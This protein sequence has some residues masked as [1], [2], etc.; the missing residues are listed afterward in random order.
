[1][2]LL[3]LLNP[4]QKEAVITTA[5]P[6]LIL[7]GAGSGKT[8]VLTSRIAYMIKEQGINPW[9]I[10]AVTF[11]NKAARE[12]KDRI[13]K[14]I[15][16]E[17]RSMWVGTFHS[18]C[19][20]ILRREAERIGY[21]RDFVIYDRGDQTALI[22]Q[23]LKDYNLDDQKISPR[24]FISQISNLKNQFITP[25]KFSHKASD[26]SD[27]NLSNVY[28][29]YEKKMFKNNAFDF[30]D[31]IIKTVNLLHNFPDVLNV[32][33]DQF[34][35]VL[36]D[37]YQDT[38]RSQYLLIT[39][40][41]SKYRNICVVG[42]DDQ[43]IYGWRGADI[44]NI[45]NFDRDFKE[46]K[47]IKLEQNYRST[48]NI[49]GAASAVIKNNV[50]RKK[51]EIWSDQEDGNLIRLINVQ[52]ERDEILTI[53]DNINEIKSDGKNNLSS[54]AILYRTNAQSRVLEEG[55]RREG[56]PYVIFG[57]TQFYARKE[58]KDVL[59]Y[60]KVIVNP[61][62]A[63]SL[64]RII[65]VPKRDIGDT[66]VAKLEMYAYE[67]SL[68]LYEVFSQLDKVEGIK[69]KKLVSLTTLGLFIS[70]L[71]EMVLEAVQTSIFRFNFILF[72]IAS[73]TSADIKGSSP[74]IFK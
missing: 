16:K 6:L 3:N 56:L 57:G 74:W 41:A 68:H 27:K 32:Y 22:K 73:I 66:T 10:L 18:I 63:V 70:F 23:I 61:Q 51:K 42:D 17:D 60:L 5:G 24:I 33:Q 2:D 20:R 50:D 58:I 35:Y 45:L 8:R 64:K 38:N 48:K 29:E 15:G 43:S 30:D 7:A 72:R 71:S 44:T 13:T 46:A 4:Q 47:V 11:T 49:L 26:Y 9:N 65:N 28:T 34:K 14:I 62:D 59:A 36:V 31:L 69:G 25:D 19:M 37:E 67:N 40:L 21:K 1:M 12:M 52:N 55:L 53:I 39:S 54:I